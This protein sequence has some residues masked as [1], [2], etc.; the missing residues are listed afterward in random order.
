MDLYG[1][2]G[3]GVSHVVSRLGHASRGHCLN[4]LSFFGC[5]NPKL[6]IAMNFVSPKG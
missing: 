3:W 2:G 4:N 5:V 6:L 1:R